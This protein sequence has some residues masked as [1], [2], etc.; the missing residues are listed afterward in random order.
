M[1]NDPNCSKLQR[2]PT[3]EVFIAK[4]IQRTDREVFIA[5]TIQKTDREVFISRVYRT[6]LKILKLKTVEVV[7]DALFFDTALPCV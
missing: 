4:T 3:R 2:L 7:S 5:K 6:F 1:Y